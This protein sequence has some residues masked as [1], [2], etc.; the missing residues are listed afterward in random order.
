MSHV[1]QTPKLLCW[2]RKILLDFLKINAI[3]YLIRDAKTTT[4]EILFY[5]TRYTVRMLIRYFYKINKYFKKQH[6]KMSTVH[7][8]LITIFILIRSIFRPLI[9]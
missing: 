2:W 5:S 3:A 7:N 1:R 8:I 4:Q 6:Q 9:A